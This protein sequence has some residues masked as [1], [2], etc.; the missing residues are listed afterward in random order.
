VPLLHLFTIDPDSGRPRLVGLE[1]TQGETP[2][3]FNIDPSG[4][5]LIVAN[6]G[7][8]SLVTF[9]IETSTGKLRPAGHSA[10]TPMP[11]CVE[12]SSALR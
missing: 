1:S 6:V 2:R 7:S 5:F 12:F 11:V 4:N 10:S 3:N 9:H 8:N